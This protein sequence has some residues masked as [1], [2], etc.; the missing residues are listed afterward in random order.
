MSLTKKMWI[1]TML[2]SVIVILSA[3]G[4]KVNQ[5]DEKQNQ[6]SDE[7]KSAVTKTVNTI[8]GDIQIPAHPQRIVVDLYQNDLLALGIKPVGSVKYFLD[9]PY[10]KDLVQGIESI[11]DRSSVSVEKVLTLQPDLILI[12]SKDA[13]EYE[14]YSK[15]APTLVI[16][17]GTYKNVHEELTAFGELL[18]KEQEAKTWLAQYDQRM[19]AARDKLKGIVQP[20][21]TFTVMEATDKEYYV[22]GDNFGR[23]GQAVYRGLNLTPPP[24]VQ[25][26]L[27]GE[28][29]WK[30][31]SKEV[32]NQY[33]G[34]Y[35]FLTVN[36]D[37]SGYEGD[38]IW[39]SLSA[40]RNGKVFELQEDR[41]WYF[42]PIAIMGQAEELADMIVQ[43][44]N[45][46][47][48]QK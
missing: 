25:K 10:S 23:G 5:P 30:S 24:L 38:S 9:N 18:G 45:E 26:E 28:T 13:S 14:K 20:G 29:Q 4:G 48:S 11:G 15:I 2:L 39:K 42:D 32:I 31:I 44:N 41:Y 3:C 40:V 1:V 36:K 34:S 16:P 33:A 35:I 12:A 6:A 19:Q 8:H 17:Y 22:Y 37:L 47:V 7:P 21:D 27:L 43:R 46:N